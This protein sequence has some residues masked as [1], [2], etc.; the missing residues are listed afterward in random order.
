VIA[1]FKKEYLKVACAIPPKSDACY[2]MYSILEWN[3]M[4]I[5]GKSEQETESK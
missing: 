5:S 2:G 1:Y 3:G 4:E